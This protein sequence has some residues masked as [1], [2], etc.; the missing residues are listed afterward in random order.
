MDG[1]MIQQWADARGRGQEG[2]RGARSVGG[3]SKPLA[4]ESGQVGLDAGF[5]SIFTRC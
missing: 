4:K 1:W 5:I 2:G 3:T